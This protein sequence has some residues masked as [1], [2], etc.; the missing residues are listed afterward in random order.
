MGDIY[1]DNIYEIFNTDLE[2]SNIEYSDEA[3]YWIKREEEY[4]KRGLRVFE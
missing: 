4:S 3:L 1:S 2:L